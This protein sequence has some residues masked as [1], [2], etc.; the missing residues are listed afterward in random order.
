MF[1]TLHISPKD[2]TLCVLIL[3]MARTETVVYLS[4]VSAMIIG[5]YFAITIIEKNLALTPATKTPKSP[6]W[7]NAL[8]RAIRQTK[9]SI[10]RAYASALT[11]SS[12]KIPIDSSL[13]KWFLP[14]AYAALG[15]LTASLT[16]L[17]AKATANLVNATFVDKIN[18]FTEFSSW[19][20]VGVTVFT[21][22]SQ[23]YWINRGL[24]RYD[25]LLQIPAFHTVWILFD[26]IG[27]GIYYHEFTGF[28]PL[29]ASMFALGI[30]TI[31]VGVFV[32]AKRLQ[33]IH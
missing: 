18:Q 26:V 3:L 5:L 6:R 9:R 33:K 19:A 4:I 16:V 23:I 10:S 14:F 7:D 32:L 2:Y 30:A 8:L 25:A 15:G 27:G 22:V 17:F 11:L 12:C 21:A 13:V 28:T 20:I 29:Q 31:F 1:L 24:Q